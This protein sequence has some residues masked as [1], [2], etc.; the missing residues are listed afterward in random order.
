MSEIK[1]CCRWLAETKQDFI[2]V[3]FT[4]CDG[5]AQLAADY[6]WQ[7]RLFIYHSHTRSQASTEFESYLCVNRRGQLEYRA[8][9]CEGLC[10]RS[11]RNTIPY[12][13]W[14]TDEAVPPGME[15]VCNDPP[16]NRGVHSTTT[17]ST[18][19]PRLCFRRTAVDFWLWII[20]FVCY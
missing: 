14:S 20:C 18:R 16:A 7:I 3:F 5:F 10:P 11:Q 9:F 17:L 13:L 19:I 8:C 6:W 2:S 12:G 15:A 4:M 1:H